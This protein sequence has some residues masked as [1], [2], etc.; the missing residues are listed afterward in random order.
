M[1]FRVSRIL[2]TLFHIITLGQY[3]FAIYYDINYVVLRKNVDHV[4][5]RPGFGGR[6][7]FLTYWCLVSQCA[8]H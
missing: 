5:T 1:A 6:L 7:R 2:K 8:I 4:M 3:V